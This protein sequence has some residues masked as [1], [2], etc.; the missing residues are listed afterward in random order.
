MWA[1]LGKMGMAR[2]EEVM[3]RLDMSLIK[4]LLLNVWDLPGLYRGWD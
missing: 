1:W 3:L 2:V 4:E